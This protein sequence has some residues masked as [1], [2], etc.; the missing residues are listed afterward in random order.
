MTYLCPYS[1]LNFKGTCPVT[2]CH[3]HINSHDSGCFHHL[4]KKNTYGIAEIA[5][6]QDLNFNVTKNIINKNT[7]KIK[8]FLSIKKILDKLA[9][10]KTSQCTN[11]GVIKDQDCKNSVKC[12]QRLIL[13][14][15]IH[16][17]I[18]PDIVSTLN[19]QDNDIWKILSFKDK[20]KEYSIHELLYVSPHLK[21]EVLRLTPRSKKNGRHF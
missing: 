7:T 19:L 5:Y 14:K 21:D 8:R 10:N 1:G 12:K 15:K 6:S 17:E 9:S 3:A 20:S 2:Q 4:I 13:S 18:P 11:C 16:K